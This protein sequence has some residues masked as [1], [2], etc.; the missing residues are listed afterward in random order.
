MWCQPHLPGG[1]EQVGRGRSSTVGVKPSPH[2]GP[3]GSAGLCLARHLLVPHCPGLWGGYMPRSPVVL[4]L[5][6]GGASLVIQVSAQ[7][8][9]AGRCPERRSDSSHLPQPA[10]ITHRPLQGVPSALGSQ[11]TRWI[12]SLGPLL[13][14]RGPPLTP[15]PRQFHHGAPL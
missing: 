15:S 10:S 7:Q 13:P 14:H 9:S 6:S 3:Q 1:G 4:L 12:A 5:L 8:P 11:P 2:C